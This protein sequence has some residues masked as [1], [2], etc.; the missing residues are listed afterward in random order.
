MLCGS[1]YRMVDESPRWLM[2]TGKE[3]KAMAILQKI[4]RVNKKTMPNGKLS[5]PR[6]NVNEKTG[7]VLYLFR[8]RSVTKITLVMWFSWQVF[9][10]TSSYIVN[11]L[12][13]TSLH[14]AYITIIV[15]AS[16]CSEYRALIFAGLPSPC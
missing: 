15:F 14:A 8:S 7:N 1:Y 4:A 6:L 9:H 2:V 13:W 5:A 16:F 11:R 3:E 12:I 10:S